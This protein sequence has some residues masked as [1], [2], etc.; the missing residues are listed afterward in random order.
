[1]ENIRDF[2]QTLSYPLYFLDFETMQPVIPQFPGT[3]LK[4]CELDT[5]AMVKVWEELVRVTGGEVKYE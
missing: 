5:Y 4:Y 3:K 1:M 2:L